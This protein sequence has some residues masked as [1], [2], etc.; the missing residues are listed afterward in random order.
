MDQS[1]SA[2]SPN[3]LGVHTLLLESCRAVMGPK[4]TRSNTLNAERVRDMCTI[5]IALKKS[6]KLSKKLTTEFGRDIKDIVA[7]IEKER[8][9]MPSLP[10][11]LVRVA[12]Q[13]LCDAFAR[14]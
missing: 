2:Y 13:D 5:L 3:F 11:Q 9:P 1:C 8:S 14:F 7:I 10:Q 6:G 12:M 4:M